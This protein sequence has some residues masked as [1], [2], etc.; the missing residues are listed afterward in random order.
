MGRK[1]SIKKAERSFC[2]TSESIEAM[3]EVEEKG[4]IESQLEEE[5]DVLK[6][7]SLMKRADSKKGPPKSRISVT[8]KS[9]NSFGIPKV[10]SNTPELKPSFAQSLNTPGTR[11]PQIR[12]SE[13]EPAETKSVSTSTQIKATSKSTDEKELGKSDIKLEP[14]DGRENKRKSPFGGFFSE[15]R[16]TYIE[17]DS[18]P[19]G[20]NGSGGVSEGA[21][22]FGEESFLSRMTDK[23]QQQLLVLKK[24]YNLNEERYDVDLIQM[25]FPNCT[26]TF[27]EQVTK[28]F[29]GILRTTENKKASKT[30]I[31]QYISQIEDS[32]SFLSS[33]AIL[34]WSDLFFARYLLTRKPFTVEDKEI[35]LK[36]LISYTSPNEDPKLVKNT[37]FVN[38]GI[39]ALRYL[40]MHSYDPENSLLGKVISSA[41]SDSFDFADKPVF[42]ENLSVEQLTQ[43]ILSWGEQKDPQALMVQVKNFCK[44]LKQDLMNVKQGDIVVYHDGNNMRYARFCRFVDQKTVELKLRP[45]NAKVD[46]ASVSKV[47]PLS[48]SLLSL[49][50]SVSSKGVLVE[51]P[52]FHKIKQCELQAKQIVSKILDNFLIESGTSFLSFFSLLFSIFLF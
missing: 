48:S 49:F 26:K 12:T 18:L 19:G 23:L 52:I 5:R 44:A 11:K 33:F 6:Q 20:I 24:K 15:A 8:N 29:E 42:S 1:V 43:K 47:R 4:I 46:I 10:Y 51:D 45:C 31:N 50:N 25:Y 32:L 27:K 2:G 3:E 9:S 7:V 38:L 17:I 16:K 34:D 39:K 28:F 21:R 41:Y 30:K 14:K 40:E 13:S 37:Q 22:V 35:I 36:K